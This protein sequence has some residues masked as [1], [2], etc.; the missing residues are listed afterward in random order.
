MFRAKRVP[1]WTLLIQTG[2][3]VPLTSHTHLNEREW[4]FKALRGVSGPVGSD[5][6]NRPCHV[7]GSPFSSRNSVHFVLLCKINT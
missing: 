6:F 4:R 7:S 5:N 3:C 1:V 2:A